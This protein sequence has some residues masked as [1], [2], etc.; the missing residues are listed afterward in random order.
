MPLSKATIGLSSI[1]TTELPHLAQN[2]WEDTADE[3][4][5]EGI[6]HS[7]A[8]ST[9]DEQNSIH[10]AVWQPECFWHISQEQE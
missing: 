1:A 2:A 3:R 9:S 7:P 10:T 8:Y 4:N 5:K 6:P